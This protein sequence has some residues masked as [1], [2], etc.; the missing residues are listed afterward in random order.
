MIPTPDSFGQLDYDMAHLLE[1][2]VLLFSFAL[3]YQRRLFAV[4]QTYT[5]Q[6]LTVAAACFWQAHVQHSADLFATG[7]VTLLAKGIGFP[8]A[9][10]RIA[11]RTHAAGSVEMSFGVFPSLA[12]GL[13]L[14][15]LAL[16]VVMRIPAGAALT[17]ETL[18][19][20]LS[21]LLLGLAM[22]TTRSSAITQTIGFLSVENGL[23]LAAIGVPGMP[24]VVELS[25]AFLVMVAF[26]VFGIFFF[27]IRAQFDS[28][29][30]H[31]LDRI[32]EAPE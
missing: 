27:R 1:G 19:M 9:L 13:F 3:L 28:L 31:H 15:C 7:I 26:I 5:A 4:I 30:L 18:A 22:M 21:V 8:W 25:V 23:S 20:S 12:L 32:T 2:T 17:R 14:A 6:A 11:A 29:E 24:I 10:T 16:L